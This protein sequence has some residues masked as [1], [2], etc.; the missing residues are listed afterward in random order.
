MDCG[1]DAGRRIEAEDRSGLARSA[2]LRDA[3]EQPI[4]GAGESGDWIPTGIEVAARDGAGRP[5]DRG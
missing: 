4:D 3:I 1:G 5:I 2:R